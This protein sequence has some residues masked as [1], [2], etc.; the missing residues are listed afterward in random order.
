MHWQ[1]V[2][3][4]RPHPPPPPIFQG[5]D[6]W[7]TSQLNVALIHKLCGSLMCLAYFLHVHDIHGCLYNQALAD[8]R[9]TGAGVRT[10]LLKKQSI[11][12][13]LSLNI[14]SIDKI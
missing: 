14:L 4:A 10:V 13:M 7:M 6:A 1:S 11:T 8:V 9:S 12:C 3:Y 5:M 2:H